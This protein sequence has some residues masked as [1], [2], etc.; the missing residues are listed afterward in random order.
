MELSG[1]TMVSNR[2]KDALFAGK[3]SIE[4]LVAMFLGPN[5]DRRDPL[6]SPLYADLRGLPPLYIQ[7]GGEEVLVDDSR[8][9]TER[10]RAAGVEVQLDIVPGAQHCFLLNA[11]RVP[12][13]DAGIRRWADW[14]RP[15]LG[16]ARGD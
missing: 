13:A 4:P 16:L 12:E 5:G 15:K 2:G 11:G 8:R 14:L 10:A 7:V 3:E 9:I 6:A 1:E